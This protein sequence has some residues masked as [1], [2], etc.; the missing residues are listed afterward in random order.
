[1]LHKPLLISPSAAFWSEAARALLSDPSLSPTVTGQ[2]CDLSHLRVVVPTFAHAQLLKTALLQNAGGAFVPPRMST[3]SGWCGL[4]PPEPERAQGESARLMDL[5]AELR[6]HAWLKKLF[7][8]RRNT[9]LLPLAQMLLT[10][11]D[12]LTQS[13]LPSIWNAQD[14]AEDRWQKALAQLTPAAQQIVSDE[15]QLVWSI[16]KS[17]LDGRDAL[18]MRYRQMM[19]LVEQAH[20]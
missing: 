14:N 8:A 5:Y 3:L 4:L 10:L 20:E 1:M 19:S 12:E 9:D 2:A 6:Q 16:W 18:A 11:S 17:Q 13:L 15:A 7:S